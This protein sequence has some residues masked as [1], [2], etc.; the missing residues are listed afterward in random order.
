MNMPFRI[1]SVKA[2]CG[3]RIFINEQYIILTFVP[4]IAGPKNKFVVLPEAPLTFR[5][6]TPQPLNPQ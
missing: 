5:L 6:D 4:L 1:L 3:C 2:V